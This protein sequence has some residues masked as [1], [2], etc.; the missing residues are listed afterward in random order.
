MKRESSAE[1][2]LIPPQRAV[3]HKDDGNYQHPT[4]TGK[5]V[6]SAQT[7]LTHHRR[8]ALCADGTNPPWENRE[9]SAQTGLTHHGRTAPLCATGPTPWE[10]GTTLHN[11]TLTMGERASLC[12]TGLSHS[13]ENW[14]LSAQRTLSPLRENWPLSAQRF[15][16]KSDTPV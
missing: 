9:H 16:P 8:G 12:A 5:E 2:A 6:H 10:N 3:L 13:W 11:R 15:L 1:R 7:G 4:V 14:H